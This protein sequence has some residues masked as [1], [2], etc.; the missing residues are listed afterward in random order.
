MRSVKTLTSVTT[1]DW[2]P[3]NW[4]QKDFKVGIG[5][6]ITGT[7]T[8]K[9]EV[10]HENIIAGETPV[11]M[12]HSSLTTVSASVAGAQTSPVTGIRLNCTAYTSGAVTMT[13]L[14]G[15]V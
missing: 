7:N 13:V 5:I 9:V 8:S 10:C 12:D 11:P 1:S 6:A 4:K 2:I 14:Q 3:V 15:V